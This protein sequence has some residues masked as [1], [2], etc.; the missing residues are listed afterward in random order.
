HVV[1]RGGAVLAALVQRIEGDAEAGPASRIEQP[2][3]LGGLRDAIQHLQAGV[4][5]VAALPHHLHREMAAA[6]QDVRLPAP[7]G[8]RPPPLRWA[9]QH[10]AQMTREPPPP[11]EILK[12]GPLVEVQPARPPRPSPAEG[13]IV[14]PVF[15]L[16]KSSQPYWSRNALTSGSSLSGGGSSHLSLGERFWRQKS[17]TLR[18]FSVSRFS[19]ANPFASAKARAPG[20]TSNTWS[21]VSITTLAT[22]EGFFTPSRE[23]TAPARAVGPCIT[24][25]SSC[26]TPS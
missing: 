3:L 21:V 20:P 17:Q 23:A 10:L 24:Q 13:W 16:R 26:T 1:H 7:G 14:P 5:R 6:H 4:L 15:G 18:A 2:L 12:K 25:A 11:R 19:R 9:G 22:F 8:A